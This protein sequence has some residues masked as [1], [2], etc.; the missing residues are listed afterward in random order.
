MKR[1]IAVG[2]MAAVALAV[3]P[4]TSEAVIVATYPKKVCMQSTFGKSK[5][6]SWLGKNA[7]AVWGVAGFRWCEKEPVNPPWKN[8][9]GVGDVVSYAGP[10][11][12]GGT[13]KWGRNNDWQYDG[14]SNRIVKCV[15]RAPTGC[16][17]VRMKVWLE[18]DRP[19]VAGLFGD[20]HTMKISLLVGHGLE[21]WR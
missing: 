12:N 19:G 21:L 18:F 14:E 15:N 20:H 6:Y 7:P 2:L 8:G 5:N 1:A 13:T 11:V 4:Q 10:V 16:D 3:L 9:P 17:Y